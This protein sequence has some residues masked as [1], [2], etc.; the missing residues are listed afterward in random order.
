VEGDSKPLIRLGKQLK[1][2]NIACDV[3]SFGEVDQNEQILTEFVEAVN[4]NGNRCVWG[5]G[6]GC[7]CGCSFVFGYFLHVSI[8]EY[9]SVCECVFT[10]SLKTISFSHLVTVPAGPHLLSDVLISTPIIMGENSSDTS[11]TS[12]VGGLSGVG[13][14]VEDPMIAEVCMCMC[15]YLVLW[16]C[17]SARTCT[18][19]HDAYP[20]TST[21]THRYA[22]TSNHTHTHT[23]THTRKHSHANTHSNV[24]TYP[25]THAHKP[26]HP[27]I[28][29]HHTPT[30]P[31]RT[32]L[33]RFIFFK[34]SYISLSLSLSL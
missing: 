22:H 11:T 19:A 25:R 6:C 9:V 21:H 31:H 15:E 17:N 33:D 27:H 29:S 7:G 34:C 16:C 14:D 28:H 1:K 30:H 4:K 8:C 32:P 3:V 26:T 10:G 2:S 18:H 23:R 5:C 24:H 12:T 20:H 13:G